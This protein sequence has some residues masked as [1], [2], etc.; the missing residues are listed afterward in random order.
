MSKNAVN[1]AKQL[2]FLKE[3]GKKLQTDIDALSLEER[4]FLGQ[5]LINIGNG[6]DPKIEF[7]VNIGRGQTSAHNSIKIDN[8][9]RAFCGWL[10]IAMLPF[11]E[12]G[13][14]MSLEEA[15][16]KCAASGGFGLTEETMRTYGSRYKEYRKE[17]FEL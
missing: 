13:L 17:I 10:H 5:A 8:N 3:L 16:S 6:L 1:L 2:R 15:V 4:R 11:S 9:I 14:D 7:G 12:G